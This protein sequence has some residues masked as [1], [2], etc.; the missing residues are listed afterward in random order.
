MVQKNAIPLNK[1]TFFSNPTIPAPTVELVNDMVL[2][3]LN[4]SSPRYYTYKI[5]RSDY[6]THRT[7]YEG[8]YL[9]LFE[10][11]SI[12]KDKQYVYT[13]TPIYKEHTGKPIFLPP[14]FTGAGKAPSWE[15]NLMLDKNWW[16]Y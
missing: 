13:V 2:V 15:D 5:E 9:P 8:E 3:H 11:T 16:D 1:S 14:I 10:D 7:L 4:E 6:A 12:E